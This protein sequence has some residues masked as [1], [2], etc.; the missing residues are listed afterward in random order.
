MIVVPTEEELEQFDWACQYNPN[1]YK[2]RQRSPI[3]FYN[4]GG[5][6]TPERVDLQKRIEDAK[7]GI[8][9][10]GPI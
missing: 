7:K 4:S 9:I 8:E 6:V 10:V 1:P 5:K 3:G 2:M